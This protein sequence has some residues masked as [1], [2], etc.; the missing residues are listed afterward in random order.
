MNQRN[1]PVRTNCASDIGFSMLGVDNISKPPGRRA[2]KHCR[3]KC[4]GFSRC[5]M[6]SSAITQSN[7]WCNPAGRA[8]LRLSYHTACGVRVIV[9]AVT[10]LDQAALSR[11][12]HK[13]KMFTAWS[14]SIELDAFHD[15]VP[16]LLRLSMGLSVSGRKAPF[17]VG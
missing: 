15:G 14:K 17:S 2:L 10:T 13:T 6:I 9:F 16:N 12:R 8:S 4:L 11:L 1:C 7:F 3:S 5:S